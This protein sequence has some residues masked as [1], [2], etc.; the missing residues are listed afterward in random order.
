MATSAKSGAAPLARE[1]SRGMQAIYADELSGVYLFGSRAR[2]DAGAESDVD[3]LIILKRIQRYGAEVDRTGELVSRL[4][5][6]YGVSISRVFMTERQWR[7]DDSP[8]LRS[9]RREAL[10]A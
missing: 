10:P 8:F 2:G 7:E 1:L 3:V 6:D 4:A 5:L 9:V